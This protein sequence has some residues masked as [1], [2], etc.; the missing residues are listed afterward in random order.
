MRTTVINEQDFLRASGRTVKE[1]RFERLEKFHEAGTW[2]F[3]ASSYHSKP[4]DIIVHGILLAGKCYTHPLIPCY[5]DEV[6]DAAVAS[7]KIQDPDFADEC[8]R[9]AAY[10]VFLHQEADYER[11]RDNLSMVP[12]SLHNIPFH[13]YIHW[14]TPVNSLRTQTARMLWHQRLGHPSDHYL[15]N[16]HKF[17]KGVPDMNRQSW[18]L[19]PHV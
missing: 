3:T 15:Y 8:K 6:V 17:V 18:M 2:T 7:L 9:A 11:L 16:A 12:L 14:N 13:E 10:S 1:F 19:V 4:R 5:E